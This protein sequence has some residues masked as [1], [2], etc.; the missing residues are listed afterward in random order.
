MTTAPAH[1]ASRVHVADRHVQDLIDY[2]GLHTGHLELLRSLGPVLSGLDDA[3][4][5]AF[6]SHVLEQPELRQIIES[7]SSVARLR[8]TLVNYVAT[9]WSGRYDDAVVAHRV[10]IG[11]VHDRIRL[12]LGAYLGAFVQIDR[13]VVGRL[14]E[15]LGGEPVALADAL[16]AWRTLTQTDMAIVA[17]SFIDA[18]DARLTT[19]LET[20]SATG[21]EVAAQTA[22]VKL[23]VDACVQA[24]RTG[25]ESVGEAWGA[26]EVMN[27]SIG[28]LQNSVTELRGQFAHIGEIVSV[29]GSISDQTKLLSLN[30]RIEAARAGEHG[31]GFAVVAN[32]VGLLAERTAESLSVI[33]EHNAASEGT[34]N[35]VTAAIEGAVAQV[36]QVRD[37]TTQA[38][39]GFQTAENEVAGVAAMVAE[40][41]TGMESIVAQA[42]DE[43]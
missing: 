38:R 9:L 7:N 20:L 28:D 14:V 5:E 21:Q 15:H 39:T 19:L 36:G 30:A 11:K 2:T 4:A 40:I 34:L 24:T 23:S 42:A 31:R 1:L 25:A 27:T 12:P 16:M 43:S 35:Q 37:A 3:I 22:E 29:I 41:E 6:Y 13:V 32:E 26:V 18:R 17:Q 10:T 8:S 33:S